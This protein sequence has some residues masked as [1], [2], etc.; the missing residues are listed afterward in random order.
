MTSERSPQ[1]G[2]DVAFPT[3]SQAQQQRLVSVGTQYDEPT[4]A[5]LFRAGDRDPD[6][7]YLESGVVDIVRPATPAEPEAIVA[8]HSAGRFLGELNMLS[9]QAVYLTARMR[10][11]GRIHRISPAD[12]RR[13][14]A[15]D[16]ELSDLILK[17][18]LAR[19][20]ILRTGEGAR[21]IEIIGSELCART[22]AL[23]NWAARQHLPHLYLD[24]DAPDGS[25]LAER[26]DLSAAD[27]PAVITTSAILRFA[28]PGELAEHLGLAYRRTEGKTLDVAVIGG[29]PAG[30]AAAVYGASEGLDTMLLDGSN[31]G[32]QAAA[33]S[34]IENY[35]GFP[36]GLSG[37]ELT[38]RALVQA[39]KFGARVASPCEVTAI[40]VNGDRLTVT[41]ADGT[42]VPTRAVVVATGASYQKLPLDHWARFEGA[43]IFYAATELE[44]RACATEPV[45]VIGGANSAGQAAIYLA[46]RGSPVR[47]ILRGPDLSARMSRYL[48]D[49][50][51]A[52]PR[53]E[54]DTGAE[55]TDL[56]GRQHLETID[57]TYRDRDEVSR[58]TCS[59][60]FCFIGATPATDWLSGLVLDRN[61][62]V[63]TDTAL[64][65]AGLSKAW[66][67]LGRT[68]L[69]YETSVPAIFAAGDVR[70]GSMKRVA[71]AVGE[72]ASAIRSVHQAIGV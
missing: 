64:D 48:V 45:A 9:G 33:S 1:A 26:L 15:G 43:G 5:I 72:G 35:L 22:H 29:G 59:G 66:Q 70:S 65:R 18:L 8:T 13:M 63:L 4:G 54:V 23:R 6:F 16:A 25:A 51:L 38:Q 32:G 44:A 49:R 19:R 3:L 27:L 30:L 42:E 61:G 40:G 36:S 57:V 37:D 31:V 50:V 34:R 55:V 24:V 10:E 71:A 11:P 53:I 62:F 21:S 68:P 56:D 46:D 17:A 7:I 60:L 14:M 47:L 67:L 41:L 58:Y 2:L 39:Q 12:F 28:S 52:H 20:E 69:P